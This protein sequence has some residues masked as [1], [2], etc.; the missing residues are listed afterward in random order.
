M[1]LDEIIQSAHK[2]V[3]DIG[4][5]LGHESTNIELDDLMTDYGE[6]SSYTNKL[7]ILVK[8]MLLNR[9]SAIFTT[10]AGESLDK[11]ELEIQTWTENNTNYHA[12]KLV[13]K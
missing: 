11:F 8:A 4:K 7:E 1:N 9:V 2:M 3:D 12:V 5:A 6:L 10:P 13:T